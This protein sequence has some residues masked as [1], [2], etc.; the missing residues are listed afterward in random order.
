MTIVV[1]VVTRDLEA[2]VR[3]AVIRATAR[4]TRRIRRRSAWC[5]SR[6]GGIEQRLTKRIRGYE[7]GRHQI[8]AGAV[9][10]AG[11]QAQWG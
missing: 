9:T 5:V 2:R 10:L 4:G 7:F 6:K 3:T 1:I 8:V 11:L